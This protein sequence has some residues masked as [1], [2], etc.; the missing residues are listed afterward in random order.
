M[1]GKGSLYSCERSKE[2]LFN[3]EKRININLTLYLIAFI[4][5]VKLEPVL[6]LQVP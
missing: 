3:L 2:D 4:D 1:V 5:T 6:L